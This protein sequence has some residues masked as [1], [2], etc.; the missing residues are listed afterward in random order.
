MIINKE[1]LCFIILMENSSKIQRVYELLYLLITFQISILLF[2]FII[3]FYNF[4][5]INNFIDI[6]KIQ[7]IQSII[8][9]FLQKLL[10]SIIERIDLFFQSG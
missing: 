4:Y 8:F 6:L 9:V 7:H 5:Q 1:N 2:I 10:N 3:G